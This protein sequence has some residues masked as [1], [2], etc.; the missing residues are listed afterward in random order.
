MR[1]V[2]L[3]QAVEQMSATAAVSLSKDT[4]QLVS[5][6]EGYVASFRSHGPMRH[7]AARVWR[8]ACR[9]SHY[10]ALGP[11]WGYLPASESA[12]GVPTP[13][14]D[15]CRQ[16]LRLLSVAAVIILLNR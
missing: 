1:H 5:T 6:P 10:L 7:P 8:A 9:L 16:P 12:G 13:V 3:L 4:F 11:A 14:A 2:F 15:L